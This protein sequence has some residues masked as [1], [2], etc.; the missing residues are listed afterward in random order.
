MLFTVDD[1]ARMLRQLGSGLTEYQI[2]KLATVGAVV[3]PFPPKASG[4]SAL[5]DLPAL[6]LLR[7]HALLSMW[8]DTDARPTFLARAITTR[9]AQRRLRRAVVSGE[10]LALVFTETDTPGG[11]ESEADAR[12]RDRAPVLVLPWRQV[13]AGLRDVAHAYRETHGDV[14]AGHK[15]QSSA[16][17]LRWARSTEPDE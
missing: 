15:F 1:C 6:A 11:V 9:E 17:A 8:S 2:R 3:P 16:A 10:P 13:V 5:Y 7:A 4:A 14:W 12:Q